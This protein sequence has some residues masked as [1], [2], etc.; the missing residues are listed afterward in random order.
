MGSC[1]RKDFVLEDTDNIV[2]KE[3]DNIGNNGVQVRF[4]KALLLYS[5]SLPTNDRFKPSTTGSVLN[6][7]GH[8]V[9]LFH[10]LL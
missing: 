4:C 10:V 3:T 6:R 2:D 1:L 8:S 5:A 7:R 9:D